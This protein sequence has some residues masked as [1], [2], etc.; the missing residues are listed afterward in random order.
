MKEA[1]ISNLINIK[2]SAKTL[3][4]K[5]IDAVNTTF[6]SDIYNILTY[7][8]RIE[9]INDAW[10]TLFKSIIKSIIDP[11]KNIKSRFIEKIN[12]VIP[13]SRLKHFIMRNPGVILN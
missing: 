5:I 1:F 2:M 10:L 12:I 4:K 13:K 7:H 6:K 9:T 3:Q 8:K 11:D